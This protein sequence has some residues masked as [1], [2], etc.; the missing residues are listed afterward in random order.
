MPKESTW[1]QID[2]CLQVESPQ[3]EQKPQHLFS[4]S[5]R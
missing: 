4:Y 1:T 5:K 2:T 3:D